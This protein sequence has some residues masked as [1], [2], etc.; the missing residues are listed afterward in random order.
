MPALWRSDDPVHIGFHLYLE[1]QCQTESDLGN[2]YKG[3]QKAQ[4][5]QG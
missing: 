2:A 3:R 4:I 5:D 1:A